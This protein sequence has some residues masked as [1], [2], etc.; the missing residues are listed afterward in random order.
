MYVRAH[1]I[2][3]GAAIFARQRGDSMK[4]LA[5]LKEFFR[6]N[7][8]R[9]LTGIIYLISVDSIQLITP[10]IVGRVADKFQAGTL[11]RSDLLLYASIILGLAVITAIGRF[12]WRIKVMGAARLMDLDLRNKLFLKLQSLST[13]YFNKH[14][15]GDLMAHS[16]ND[17]HAIRMA[18]GNGIVM[19]V[20]AIFLTTMTV[21]IMA[22]TID[23][24]LTL[25]AL[26]PLP[27]LVAAV[28][29][30][31]RE[32]HHRFR[33]VQES[34][35]QLTDRVQENL[36]GIRVV[37]SF[38]QEEEEIKSF[39][40]ANRHNVRM[41]M[42]LVRVWGLFFPLIQFISALCFL[43]VI[44]YGGR[45]VVDARISLG[46]FVA[47]TN[48]LGLLIWPMMAIGWVINMIQRGMASLERLNVIFGERPD[49]VDG[50]DTL[51]IKT[52]SGEVTIRDLTFTYPGAN[53]PAL[54]D[55]NLHIEK[56]RT[57]AVVGRTGSGK[58]TLVNLLLRLYNPP[59][60][61]VMLDGHDVNRI[62]L[63]TLRENIG[64]VPQDNFLFST[65]IRENIGFAGEGYS[66]A[67]I[68]SA[69]RK[70][71]VYDNIIEFPK[72]FETMVGERGVTLSGGQ[73]QRVGI[74]RALIKDPRLLILDDCLSAVDTQTEEAIL[75]ELRREM[76]GRTSIIISHRISS[77]KESDEIIVLDGGRIIERGT[78]ESLLAQQGLYWDLY[79]K[80]LLEEELAQAE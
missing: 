58:T 46:D 80:Q 8:W 20:D 41:N 34:F 76:A 40:E 63:K 31:G 4:Q 74:A 51:D 12:G 78:H 53:E 60:G 33:S 7:K 32:I 24:R 52:L 22:R 30:F 18:S 66:D 37:K 71:Q 19:C 69:S 47:F 45:L 57:L 39:E 14:K 23:W 2:L 44:A 6:K 54:K 68:E 16:T 72:Q 73:K 3:A 48:Y 29:F 17:I 50:D 28:F 10:K 27:F 67:Q 15:T 13:D 77:I 35:S 59:A 70:A 62:P 79:Q 75:T 43:V 11:L 36:A 49:I 5:I 42:R 56:G 55:I 9:Y 65:T 61:A 1:S 21:F 25:A 64:C 38:V 26:L